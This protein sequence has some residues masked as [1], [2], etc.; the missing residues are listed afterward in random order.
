MLCGLCAAVNRGGGDETVWSI[1]RLQL[2]KRDTCTRCMMYNN[3]RSLWGL[4][5]L[6]LRCNVIIIFIRM[7]ISIHSLYATQ[8]GWYTRLLAS[9]EISRNR[10]VFKCFPLASNNIRRV[11]FVTRSHA[12]TRRGVVGSPRLSLLPW[13]P[14]LLFVSFVL[15]VLS[16]LHYCPRGL[17]CTRPPLDPC[18]VLYSRIRPTH[19]PPFVNRLCRWR[20]CGRRTE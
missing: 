5:F 7:F 3:N 1:C 20:A 10:V 8:Y 12:H 9:F 16:S 6:P 14:P 19:L 2:L 17:L 18:C 11:L 15:S 4:F 13:P